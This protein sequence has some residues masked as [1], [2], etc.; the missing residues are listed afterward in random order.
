MPCK[1]SV[2]TEVKLDILSCSDDERQQIGDFL[3]LLQE[4]PL[5]E[6]RQDMRDSAFTYQLPCGYI[7]SW[8]VLGDW[9]KFALSGNTKNIT[10]RIL[11]IGR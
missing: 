7:V 5:P 10:V 3:V 6:G 8:E 4:N 1:L 11:G 2:D 9:M